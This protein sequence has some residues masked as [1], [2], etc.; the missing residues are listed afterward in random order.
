MSDFNAKVI[1]DFRQSG[2]RTPATMPGR[3]I[4]LL[5]TI[6]AK[7]GEPRLQPLMFFQQD[8]SSPWHIF[9]SFGGAPK[10][11]AWFHNIVANP[12]ID[13]EVGD[14][15]KIERVP[16][17]GRVLEGNERDTVYAAMA[18]EWPQF[19][20]YEEK[21]TRDSIPVVELTRR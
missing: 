10:D 8:A 17:H 9:A 7:S 4:L 13:I 2:G 1:A 14:G 19:A 12:D 20:E 16:V 15:T 18:R 6:G 5:H 3:P 21:T 11:P